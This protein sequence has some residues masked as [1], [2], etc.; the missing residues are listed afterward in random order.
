MCKFHAMLKTVQEEVFYSKSFS[1]AYFSLVGHILL[2][3]D[4]CCL[5]KSFVVFPIVLLNYLAKAVSHFPA[6]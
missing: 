5:L 1:Q 4:W 2:F 6:I 3:I